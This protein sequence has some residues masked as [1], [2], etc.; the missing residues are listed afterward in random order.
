M[1]SSQLKPKQIKKVF[2]SDCSKCSISSA[3]AEQAE[4]EL[5]QKR[6]ITK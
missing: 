5:K 1:L 6:L 4:I 3:T 2:S